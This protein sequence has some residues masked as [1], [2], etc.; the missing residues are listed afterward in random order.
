MPEPHDV[1]AG[2]TRAEA[3]RALGRCCGAR[4]WVEGMLVR[5]PFASTAALLAAADQIWEG[6]TAEDHLE[7]FA[8]HPRIGADL[9]PSPD[10]PVAEPGDPGGPPGGPAGGQA[11]AGPD[12]GA[13][14]AWARAEQ[15]DAIDADADTRDRLRR[16]NLAY[17]ARFGFTFIVCATGKSAGA[18]LALLEARLLNAPDTERQVA[19]REL[20][21]ITRLRLL[22]L[23]TP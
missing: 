5:A 9:S 15:A 16:G 2:M 12:L 4:R 14:A 13:T 17:D 19:A 8:H 23:A 6:L 20:A 18:M 10:R 1:L 7:A 22:K 3:A 21:Q 11:A